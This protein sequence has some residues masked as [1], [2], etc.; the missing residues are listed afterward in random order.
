MKLLQPLVACI[1]ALCLMIGP[2]RA[3]SLGTPTGP[4]VLT[5]SGLDEAS[6]P[7]GEVLF[8]IDMLR[9]LGMIEIETSSIWTE[10]KHVYTGVLLK[11]L[12]ETLKIDTD[13]LKLIALN[14]YAVEFPTLE[15]YEDGPILAYWFDGAPMSVRDKGPVW[16]IYPYDS[17]AQYRTDT[18]FARSIWQLDRIEVL[19]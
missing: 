13:L 5:V 9:A 2:A 18:T 11:A 3:D 1:A 16:L 14:D 10:G 19:R 4:V 15:A 6:F 7:G 8:D 12:V 17:D